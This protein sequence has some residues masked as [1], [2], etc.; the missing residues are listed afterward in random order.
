MKSEFKEAEDEKLCRVRDL[1]SVIKPRNE[2]FHDNCG[3]AFLI[4]DRP[5]CRPASRDPSIGNVRTP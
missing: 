2:I 4:S 3:A 1:L 5:I